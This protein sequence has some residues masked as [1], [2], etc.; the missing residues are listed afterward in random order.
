M[1]I[2]GNMDKYYYYSF[3]MQA[4]LVTCMDRKGRTNIITIAWHTPISKEPPLYGIAI[5]PKRYSHKLISETKEFVINFLPFKLVD[6]I[7]FC[8]THSGR[9]IDKVEET[10]FTLKPSEKINT[11]RIEEGYA[12]FECILHSKNTI[13]DHSF[14]IGKIENILIEE[15]VFTNDILDNKKIKPAYYVGGNSYTTLSDDLETF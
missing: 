3:P 11:P 8:G 10:K 1:K 4:V 13:G 2:K 5:A 12:H 15:K 14:L 9:E 6:K 7:H